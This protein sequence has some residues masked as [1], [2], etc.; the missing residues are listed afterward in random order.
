LPGRGISQ[1]LSCSPRVSLGDGPLGA[2]LRGRVHHQFLTRPPASGGWLPLSA[3]AKLAAA[4]GDGAGARC[5]SPRCP[6][7]RLPIYS[8]RRQGPPKL[9]GGPPAARRWL[10]APPSSR[11]GAAARPRVSGGFA[12]KS[13]PFVA[14]QVWREWRHPNPVRH[15]L[16]SRGNRLVLESRSRATWSGAVEG[17][18]QCRAELVQGSRCRRF[19]R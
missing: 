3:E 10:A 13:E 1:V 17:D 8:N 11:S 19:L 4:G 2:R 18:G 5:G 6:R 9:L 15:T 12:F 7:R 14:T 16:R